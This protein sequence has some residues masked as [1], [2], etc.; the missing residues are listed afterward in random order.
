VGLVEE[1]SLCSF[2]F[3]VGPIH[4]DHYET[5]IV[6]NYDANMDDLKYYAGTSNILKHR[7]L[8]IPSRQLS[9]LTMSNFDAYGHILKTFQRWAHSLLTMQG[10]WNKFMMDVFEVP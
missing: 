2:T 9:S 5:S 10:R 6:L 4:Y 8:P 7:N 3:K 1:I